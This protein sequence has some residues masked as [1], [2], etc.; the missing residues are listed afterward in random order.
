MTPS[1]GAA[2]RGRLLRKYVVVFVGLVGGVLMASSLVE[3]YFAYQQ[4]K[5]VIVREERATAV[6]TAAKIEEFT[7]DIERRVREIT[8]AASDDPAAAQLG[9]GKLAFRGELGAALT[10]QRE[11][12]FLRL[13]RDAPAISELSHLDVSGKEQIRVA[14]LAL[15]AA[16]SQED[17][18]QTPKFRET[19]SGKTYWSPVYFRSGAQPYLTLAVPV[20]QYAV[21]VTTA[22]ISLKPVQRA[23]AQVQA[24]R[25]GYAYVVDSRGRLF[26][27]PDIGLV[28][29]NRDLSG[30]RQVSE[31]R[32][33]RPAAQDAATVAEGLQGGQILAAHAAIPSLGWVVVVERPLAEA[34]APLQAPIV[35]SIIIFVLG[36]GLSI[37]ASVL[38]ARRMVAPIRMLQEGASRIGAGDLGHRV[39]VATG[40]ELEALGNELNRTAG[41]LEESYTTL[42]NRVEARTRELAEANTELTESLE[43][44]TATGEILRVISSSPTDVQPVFDTI[45]HSAA[46]LCEAEFG[47]VFRFD[48]EQLDFI[49][50]HGL[51]PEGH[52]ALRRAFPRSANRGSAA[53]RAV[54]DREVTHIPDVQA[55]PGYDLGATAEV[56]AFRSTVGVPMLR[57]GIP[58]GAI[59]ISRARSGPFPDRQIGLLKTFADQAVIAI[60]NVRLFTEVQARNH[61]L[62]E[63]LERQTA[64]SEVLKVISRSAFDLQPV[65]EVLAE[66]ATRLCAADWALFYRFDGRVLRVIANHGAPPR[67]LEWFSTGGQGAE[68][69]PDRASVTGR[70]AVELRTVH[71]PDVLKDPEYQ[72]LGAQQHGGFRAGLGV[73][74]LRDGSLVGVFFLA[75]NEPRPFDARPD[76]AGHDLRRP[77][78]HRH[79]ERPALQG[80]RGPQPRPHRDPRAADGHRPRSCASS[81]APRPTF[82]LSSIRSPES[83]AQLCAAQFAWV[84]RFDGQLLHFVAHHGLSAAGI[85]AVRSV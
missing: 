25:G 35:R 46:R 81:R 32:A 4:T 6:A 58:V 55:E 39:H 79:R 68:L 47:F 84:F 41:Q 49:S 13:L 1:S 82:S 54:L 70:A 62:T 29:Q 56:A 3:L 51:T 74:M 22:E 64:T 30:L 85:D 14:R 33:A 75:R 59:T 16:G 52:Q 73:P 42:E 5:A 27:H 60:E 28:R 69:P 36:L 18:S 44:Q 8:Q 72:A 23:I 10:E 7:R 71:V 78:R 38:L 20:G 77:G 65:L 2:P 17:F 80:A 53:G 11:L 15:D 40:D 26:A 45:A 50:H 37:L 19:R 61:D 66:N 76:R 34:Y 67:L 63:A 31:A 12:D 9:L 21:E 24:G 43:Q 48:G 83:A 57:D